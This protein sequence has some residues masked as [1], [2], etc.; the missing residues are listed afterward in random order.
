MT[1]E[2]TRQ[3]RLLKQTD[4][5]VRTHEQAHMA[6]GG[7]LV[8]GSSL[9]YQ[10]GPDKQ[11]YAVA[12]DVSIDIAP[13]R[14]P[15]ETI[16]KAQQI[17]AAALAPADLSTQDRRVAAEASQ[18]EMQARLEMAQGGGDDKSSGN[19]R[20]DAAIAAYQLVAATGAGASGLSVRA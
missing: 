15:E 17:K 11:R 4:Q 7:G 19:P 18:M 10:S 20:V 5:K 13:G 3:V 14:T 1:P 6:A 9:T 8:R 2:H 16:A 12:G